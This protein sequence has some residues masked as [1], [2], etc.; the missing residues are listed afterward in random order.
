VNL[1]LARL[2][3]ATRGRHER[4]HFHPAFA[5]VMAHPADMRGY[6]RLLAQLYGFHAPAEAALFAILPNLVPEL[7]DLE[8]RRKAHWLLEDLA[9]VN[10]ALG[11]DQCLCGGIEM[12]AMSRA[13]ALGTLYVTEGATL[14]GRDLGRRLEPALRAIGLR[15]AE[16]RQF[17]FAYGDAQADMWRRFCAVLVAVAE[18]FTE[19]ETQAMQAAAGTMFGLMDSWLT[20]SLAGG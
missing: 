14:G 6:A 20:L 10:A 19:A 17:Y 9:R 12:P 7:T 4:L 1:T 2:R 3:E 16:G 18:G 5:P 8:S 13:E 15:H 11:Q